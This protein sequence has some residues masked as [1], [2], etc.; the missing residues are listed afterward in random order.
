MPQAGQETN[1]HTEEIEKIEPINASE[2]TLPNQTGRQSKDFIKSNAETLA[3]V[4]LV[5]GIIGLPG[6]C[7]GFCC[8]PFQLIGLVCGI[9]SIQSKNNNRSMAIAGI[10]LCGLELFLGIALIALN[11]LTQFS[12]ASISNFPIG[13]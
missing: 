9:L 1:I 13:R 6:I 2:T 3:I 10:I 8:S 4:S 5:L 7:C 11:V 12:L